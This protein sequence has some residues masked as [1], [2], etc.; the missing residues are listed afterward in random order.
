MAERIMRPGTDDDGWA[1]IL[2]DGDADNARRMLDG[3]L[4]GRP[5]GVL[6]IGD[7]ICLA[8]PRGL[9][10]IDLPGFHRRPRVELGCRLLGTALSDGGLN[11][12]DETGRVVVWSGGDGLDE[13]L[14]AGGPTT[15][16]RQM[17]GDGQFMLFGCGARVQLRDADT[18]A[19]Q[20]I[21]NVDHP[22]RISALAIGAQRRVLVA[23]SQGVL[24]LGRV[25]DRLEL[26]G[27]CV[28]DEGEVLALAETCP[29]PGGENV[30]VA[31]DE[32]GWLH[33][34]RRL[35]DGSLERTTKLEL[36]IDGG[37]PERGDL[38]C[39]G[40]MVMIAS[41]TRLLHLVDLRPPHGDF[42][43]VHMACVS[44]GT[45]LAGVTADQDHVY[46][47][48]AFEG[49]VVLDRRLFEVC[50]DDPVI[51][52]VAVNDVLL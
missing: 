26:E 16:C 19:R 43:P 44:V 3:L 40:P 45:G 33:V 2:A 37:S 41:G 47:A 11:L 25:A 50:H 34:I 18:G 46:L 5:E 51:I 12:L 7:S 24:S 9:E 31:Y 21:G 6:R 35:A 39:E 4:G 36:E 28:L 20:A 27:S 22:G 48:D 29:E 49:L 13:I 23:R 10:V 52:R 32:F 30:I 14:S 15:R 8:T 1:P 38:H 42:A 17:T